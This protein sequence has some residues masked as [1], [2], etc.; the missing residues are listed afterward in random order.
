MYYKNNIIVKF[1]K[2]EFNF[3]VIVNITKYYY[4]VKKIQ[5]RTEYLLDK[6][7]RLYKD[8]TPLA[9]VDDDDNIIKY[10]MNRKINKINHLTIDNYERFNINK[11]YIE[12]F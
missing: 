8:V 10:C 2:N 11:N 6:N 4:I 1:E 12:A 3:Y 7:E 9:Y 5:K